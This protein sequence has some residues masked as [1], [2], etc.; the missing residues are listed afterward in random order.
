MTAWG[1]LNSAGMLSTVYGE[2]V[3][4]G[5]YKHYVGLFKQFIRCTAVFCEE[6]T[7]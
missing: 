7:V 2:G 6:N 5:C 1:F 3:C 4:T